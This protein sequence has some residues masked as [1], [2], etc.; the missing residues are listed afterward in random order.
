MK[1]ERIIISGFGKLQNQQVTFAQ[2][3]VNLL[4]EENEFGKSTIAEAICT[5]LYGFPP[6]ERETQRDL[7]RTEAMRPLSGGLYKVSLELGVGGRRL[8][9]TRDFDDDN[10]Q[11]IDL[12]TGSD[13]K[14]E[15]FQRK[16]K[17][18]IGE[19]LTRLSRTQF[20]E[21]SFISHHSLVHNAAGPDLKR[22]FEEI[23]SSSPDSKTAAQ[24][25]EA[26]S[27]GLNRLRGAKTGAHGAPVKVDTEIIRVQGEITR[28]TARLR[29]LED[30]KRR[31]DSD[32]GSAYDWPRTSK[33]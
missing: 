29:E 25:I 12:D 24:A 14:E 6:H 3:R 28:I 27:T 26:L 11:I 23:A 19:K 5:A 17:P 4:V 33:N 13:V 30:N 2:D 20:Q 32:I 18:H 15:F 1:I 16:G 8:R 31:H 7:T 10:I 9:V 22:S 21:T